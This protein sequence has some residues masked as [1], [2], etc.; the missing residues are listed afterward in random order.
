MLSFTRNMAADNVQGMVQDTIS[1]VEPL[2]P[3]D[4]EH[5]SNEMMNIFRDTFIAL[6]SKNAPWYDKCNGRAFMKVI[7]LTRKYNIPMT[8]DTVRI[9]RANFMYDTIVYRLNPKLNPQKE[10]TKWARIADRK[11]RKRAVKSVRDRLWGPLDSDFT[12]LEELN[13]IMDG[14]LSRIQNFL[15]RPDYNFIYSIGKMA[16][17][18]STIVKNSILAIVM[19]MVL[20][21]L[22]MFHVYLMG[23]QTNS[24]IPLLD[25]IK[26]VLNNKIILTGFIIYLL[27]TVRKVLFRVEDLDVN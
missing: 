20:A 1:M 16:F 22:R 27:I 17:V 10:F 12:R 4:V 15:D 21:V 13:T 18:L 19:V 25:A 23:P 6:K 9:F 2:P 7:G 24:R 5:F 26:W 8:L 14:A 11:A 3:I